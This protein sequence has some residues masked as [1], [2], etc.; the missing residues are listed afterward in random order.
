MEITEGL[1]RELYITD[2]H[3]RKIFDTAAEVIID[4]KKPLTNPINP[5]NISMVV[6]ESYVPTNND[7][8]L[9][10]AW[11]EDGELVGEIKSMSIEIKGKQHILGHLMFS[12]I[13]NK[14]GKSNRTS[15]SHIDITVINYNIETG[16]YSSTKVLGVILESPWSSVGPK[17]GVTIGFRAREVVDLPQCY[18][19]SSM[20]ITPEIA[21]KLYARDRY[22]GEI[23]DKVAQA[24]IELRG[25]EER[26]S[27]EYSTY[28]DNIITASI[29]GII[30]GELEGIT[31]SVSRE[32][33]PVYVEESLT[34]ISY[35]KGK[36]SIAG[37]LMF[38]KIYRNNLKR[39]RGRMPPFNIYIEHGENRQLI[40]GVRIISDSPIVGSEDLKIG[41]AYTFIARDLDNML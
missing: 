34:P 33:A 14:P 1:I 39:Y 12:T 41:E 24:L 29:D 7:K 36:M 31:V 27:K 3:A 5:Y 2:V 15:T 25:F 19:E 16:R 40:L 22:A 35:T 26:G 9:I 13:E 30:I 32:V 21:N 38:K 20:K 37:N 18:E 17:P 10:L 28:K 8:S 23:F 4:S 11:D 6:G